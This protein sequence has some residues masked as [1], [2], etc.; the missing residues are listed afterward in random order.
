MFKKKERI[1]NNNI[2]GETLRIQDVLNMFKYNINPSFIEAKIEKA[3][4]ANLKKARTIQM[5]WIFAVAVLL[6]TGAIAYTLIADQLGC[7][8]CYDDLRS[9]YAGSAKV[10]NA[11][12]T[13]GSAGISIK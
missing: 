2:V 3:T 12:Q 4:A 13:S 7:N 11:P 5:V 9:C 8:E 1:K 6:V 10:V